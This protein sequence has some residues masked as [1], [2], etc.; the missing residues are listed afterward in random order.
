MPTYKKLPDFSARALLLVAD[1]VIEKE[2]RWGPLS[3]EDIPALIMKAILRWEEIKADDP[4][5]GVIKSDESQEPNVSN[6]ANK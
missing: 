2:K 4:N 1:Q 5:F 6:K 3:S